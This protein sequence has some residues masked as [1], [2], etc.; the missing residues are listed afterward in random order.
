MNISCCMDVFLEAADTSTIVIVPMMQSWKI[1]FK[2]F[3]CKRTY[4]VNAA[5]LS[6]IMSYVTLFE[7]IEGQ[8]I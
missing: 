8:Q 7:G 5:K 4:A 6:W 2:S 1:M 3:H